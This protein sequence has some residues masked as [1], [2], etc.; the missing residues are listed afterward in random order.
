MTINT[1]KCAA[2]GESFYVFRASGSDYEIGLVKGREMSG[3]LQAA[4]ELFQWGIPG[5]VGDK[6]RETCDWLERNLAKAAP[7]MLEQTRGM[8]DG[9]G[10]P[11][12]HLH[13]VNHYGVLWTANGLFCS[14]VALRQTETGPVL[15]QNLDIGGDDIYFVEELHPTDGNA[16]LSDGMS[17]MTW[18]PTGVN[19][20][21]LAVGS[22]CLGAPARQGARPIIE[23][24]P[25]HFLP[26]LVLRQCA[27]APEAVEYLKEITPAIPPGAG[28][29]LNLID[30]EG[31]MAVV[32][33][34]EEHTV[35][36]QCEDGLNFTTNY[37]LDRKLQDWL[38]GDTPLEPHYEGRA[39]SIR[40]RYQSAKGEVSVKWLKDLL[41]SHEG[42]GRLCK[43]GMEEGGGYSRLSFVYY[44][45]T[46][47]MEISNGFPCE[48]EYQEF[49]LIRH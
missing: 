35:V 48:N 16:T 15:G 9:S 36:R 12:D 13:I 8:A 2:K 23:G 44:P 34:V 14:S 17:G 6:M 3:D 24:F 25:Y 20:H 47:T 38:S 46:L 45:R 32:D 33:K 37:S 4:W 19:E 27:D 43:H 29:Q 10:I 40:E 22:S 41:R 30:A 11:M 49:D 1:P 39:E 26:R 5:W 31:R 18:S 28:Y 42:L 21:G 7:W